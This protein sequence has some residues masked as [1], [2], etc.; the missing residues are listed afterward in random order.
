MGENG[1]ERANENDDQN[2]IDEGT[3][4]AMAEYV[5][6][7]NAFVNQ[8]AEME[9]PESFQLDNDEKLALGVFR[10]FWRQRLSLI[11]I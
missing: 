2:S 1:K 9:W 6:A 4:G 3:T 5:S 10:N 11:H 7:L 8:I